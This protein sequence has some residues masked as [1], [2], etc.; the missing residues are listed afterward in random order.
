MRKKALF[1]TTTPRSR[2]GRDE[3]KKIERKL[4]LLRRLLNSPERGRRSEE[5]SKAR[6]K[7]RRG[8]RMPSRGIS[9]NETPHCEKGKQPSQKAPPLYLL[10]CKR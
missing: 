7:G 1:L 8:K 2:K 4:G 3:E 9:G 10:Q 6:E 5:Y